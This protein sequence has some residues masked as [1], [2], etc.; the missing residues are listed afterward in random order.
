MLKCILRVERTKEYNIY[1]CDTFAMNLT[2]KKIY[3]TVVWRMWFDH[4][5]AGGS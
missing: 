4:K 3:I 2:D 5:D 1:E